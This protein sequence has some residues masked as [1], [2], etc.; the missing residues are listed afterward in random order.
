[1]LIFYGATS[2]HLTAIE[3]LSPPGRG[4]GVGSG[5]SKPMR[6]PIPPYNPKLKERARHLRKNM[7]QSEIMLWQ[8]LKK[9]QMMGYDFDR[10]RPIDQFIVDFYGKALSL[11]IEI[12]GSSHHSPEAQHRDQER[13]ARFESLRVRFIRFHDTDVQRDINA[14]CQAIALWIQNHQA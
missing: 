1:M 13:Q 7:T 2:A 9:K 14:V 8:R 12:D 6:Y 10:Q 5:Q 3:Y 11:A 4:H